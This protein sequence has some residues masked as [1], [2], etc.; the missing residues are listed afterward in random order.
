V[1]TE[2]EAFS[3]GSPDID[4]QKVALPKG[5]S[6]KKVVSSAEAFAVLTYQGSV[7]TW[8][9][10]GL[11]GKPMKSVRDDLRSGIKDFAATYGSMA[12]ITDDGDLFAWGDSEFGGRTERYTPA[13]PASYFG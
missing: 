10:E 4:N 8:G 9:N 6:V 11:G 2:D 7:L 13:V 5:H 12:A 1:I 3:W